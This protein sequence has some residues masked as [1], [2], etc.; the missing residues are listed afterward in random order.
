MSAESPFVGANLYLAK[1]MEDSLYLYNFLRTRGS[2][3]AIEIIGN[4]ERSAELHLFYPAKQEV[5]RATPQR[6]PLTKAKEWII[7]GPYAIDRSL[8]RS[9]ATLGSETSGVFEVFGRREVIGGAAQAAQ[10]RVIEPAFVPTP[11]PAPTPRR[12]ATK[13]PAMTDEAT[14]PAV[15]IQGTPMNFDQQAILEARS[16]TR[17]STPQAINPTPPAAPTA[18]SG[19][20]IIDEALKT[21][22][23]SS[24][25]ASLPQAKKPAAGH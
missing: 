10:V 23:L 25:T 19:K 3:R 2:P 6:D 4:S 15:A 24:P 9:V 7:R 1:E 5:Y 22:V 21:T 8:H 20:N 13:K 11:T 12:R 14:G 18:I 17:V 16:P